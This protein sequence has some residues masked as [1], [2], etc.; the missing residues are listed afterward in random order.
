MKTRDSTRVLPVKTRD[1]T[2]VLPVKTRDPTRSKIG[3]CDPTSIHRTEVSIRH[4]LLEW[5]RFYRERFEPDIPND[6]SECLNNEPLGKH[7]QNQSKVPICTKTCN[8][9]P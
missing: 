1:P 9:K 3:R 8:Y 5:D 6:L 4:R 7:S 2:R